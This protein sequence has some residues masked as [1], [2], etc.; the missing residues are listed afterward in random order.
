MC[1]EKSF[2]SYEGL[3]LR[4]LQ[5]TVILLQQTC[6]ANNNHT[7]APSSCGKITNIRHPFRLKHDP[8][9]CGDPRYE[10]A[11]ENNVTV[12]TLFSGKYYVEAINYK[13]FTIRL[14]DPGIQESDNCSSIPRYF[15]SASNFTDS[16]NYGGLYNSYYTD[17]YQATQMRE[18]MQTFIQFLH[19]IYLNCSN[20]VRDDV[21]YVDTGP[22]VKW[23]SKGH[24]YTIAGDLS[25]GNL[26][27]DCH[28][29]LIAATSVFGSR[30]ITGSNLGIYNQT[31]SYDEI[32][33]MLV[34]GFDVSWMGRPCEDLCGKR[35]CYLNETTESPG[36]EY[37]SDYC[38]TPLGFEVRC[39]TLSKQRIFVEDIIYG[40]AKGVL[41]V[42][43]WKTN[44]ASRGFS[45]SKLG[46][47]IG[48]YTGRYVLSS[49]IAIKIVLGLIVFFALLI[50]TCRR[51]HA[52][53]YEIIEDFLR[54]NTLMPIRYSYKEIKKMTRGFK[55]KLGEG[56]YGS[57]YQGKLRSGPF[58]AIKMLGK[59]KANAQDFIS[60][61]A[62]IGRIH[63][64]NVVRLIGFCFEASKR[65][66]VYEYM[67]NGSLDKYILSKEND[68]SLTYEQ[69]YDISLG[70]AR[71]IAYLHQGCDMQILHFDIK[72]HNILLD[73][74]FIPKVSDFGLA[75][76]YPIDHS[77]VTLT[78]ARGTIGY[79]APELFYQNIGGVSYKA[80]VYSFGMLLME[81]ANRRRNLNRHAD[82]SS[83]LFFPSWIYNQL[84][85]EREIETKEVSNEEKNNVKKMFLIALW[86][87]Q[88]KPTDRPSMNKVIE[89]LEGDTESIEM[90]PK[91]SFYPT[92]MIQGDLEI[93]S[94]QT[95]SDDDATSTSIFE[96][97]IVGPLLKYS[98]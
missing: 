19:V 21:Q 59:P 82:H 26:K 14:V 62:T 78:A 83:Q 39:G 76:L 1:R 20:P 60:E 31:F 46:I 32:H 11:C 52:S 50:Y 12:L 48:R 94:D 25:A 9:N 34:Y 3:L 49:Y 90:P 97:T 67:P 65:A 44:S 45:D 38:A 81:L 73:D 53:I 15:L 74:N 85:E 87:I 28:V 64:A 30:Y 75:K 33:E 61:V 13:N 66:L 37:W 17:P 22:C 56:G 4:F 10:L 24:V 80:D 8:A 40:I 96:E 27:A 58:V 77:I 2:S 93:N 86:C 95:L 54:G 84:I 51:R 23:H 29:K 92:E 35:A 79:M 47:E 43:G 63:H 36:C 6:A 98:A 70:V 41:Q 89:M 16:Y 68:I 18:G 88:L 69:M 7:C 42:I 55:Y 5:I 72:P 57:V 71:G 91:P